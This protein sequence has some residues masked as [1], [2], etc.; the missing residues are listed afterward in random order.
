MAYSDKVIEHYENPRN[1]GSLDKQD[2]D[3]GTGLVGAPACG[4]VMKLQIRV[5]DGVI[6][7]ARF[8][9]FGRNGHVAIGIAVL[10]LNEQFGGI[11][12]GIFGHR[13]DITEF[14]SIRCKQIGIEKLALAASRPTKAPPSDRGSAARM[15]TGCRKSLNSSTSTM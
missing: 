1:I 9:T 4:D 11:A 3:V 10:D 7:D 5:K 8:K 15:V 6:T 13:F 2:D 12:T 14:G